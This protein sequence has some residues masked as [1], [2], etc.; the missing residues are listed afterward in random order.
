MSMPTVHQMEHW[1]PPVPE[2]NVVYFDLHTQ[3]LV[4]Y[5]FQAWLILMKWADNTGSV[6]PCMLF[7]LTCIGVMHTPNA[8]Q[9]CFFMCKKSEKN[10]WLLLILLVIHKAHQ[11]QYFFCVLFLCESY[12]ISCSSYWTDFIN[13][14]HPTPKFHALRRTFE[15]LS[16]GLNVW[17]GPK[18]WA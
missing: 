13:C 12:M 2:V 10:Y 7:I 17:V 14:F 11:I 3:K 1:L 16:W 18:I 6:E 15:K 8:D 9:N 4:K 5:F